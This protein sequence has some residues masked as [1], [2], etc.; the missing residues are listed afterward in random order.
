M[1]RHLLFFLLFINSLLLI[2]QVYYKAN[3]FSVED[4][5]AQSYVTDCVQDNHGF[6]WFSTWNGLCRYDGYTFH[7]FKSEPGLKGMLDNNRLLKIELNSTGNLWCIAYGQNLYLFDVNKCQY[8][9]VL[10]QI[11]EKKA[12]KKYIIAV[13]PLKKGVSWIILEDGCSYRINDKNLR[14]FQSFSSFSAINKGDSIYQVIQDNSGREWI[15][16][17]KGVSILGGH[18]YNNYPFSYMVEFN[19]Q[20]YL[21][22]KDGHFACCN[23]SLENL[24]FIKLPGKVSQINQMISL[25]HQRLAF[26]TDRG[27]IIYNLA[28]NTFKTYNM[29]SLGQ[30]SC[31]VV[32]MYPDSKKRLWVFTKGPGVSCIDLKHE[33]CEWFTTEKRSYTELLKEIG[34]YVEDLNGTI[35]IM[36]NGGA[37]SYFDEYSHSLKCYYPISTDFSVSLGPNLRNFHVDRQQNLW[38]SLYHGLFRLSFYKNQFS[39]FPSIKEKDMRSFL[40]DHLGRL[41][42]GDKGGNLNVSDA[43]GKLIGYISSQG[44]LSNVVSPFSS[45][46]I[47]CMREDSQHCVWIGTKGQGLFLLVP[48]N[49]NCNRYKVQHYHSGDSGSY[50]LNNDNIYSIFE[51]K[52]YHVW[53]GTF[54]GGLNLMKKTSNGKML[55]VNY[56]NDLK[57]YPFD[58]FKNVRCITGNKRGELLVGTTKGLLTFSSAFCQAE[59]IDFYENIHIP[60]DIRSL[61][62]NDVKQVII[63]KSGRSFVCTFGGGVNEV[64]SGNLLSNNIHFKIYQSKENPALNLIESAALDKEGNI[65]VVSETSISRFTPLAGKFDV[66]G[67]S[68]FERSY[69]FLET[70]PII[71]SQGRLI[72]GVEGGRLVFDPKRVHKSSFKPNIVFSGVKFQGENFIHTLNDLSNLRLTK[73]QRSLTIYFSAIDYMD[74]S[75]IR[76]AY[77]LE[78]IDNDWSYTDFSHSA[79]YINLPAGDYKFLIHST[80]SEGVWT[81]NFRTLSVHIVPTFWETPWCWFMYLL[82]F[83][84]FTGVI[85]YIL[86]YIYRLRHQVDMEQKIT[87]I[88]LEFFTDISHE[89]RTPL[90]LIS[91][92]INEVLSHET[93]SKQGRD[94]LELVQKNTSRMLQLINQI[95][96]FRKIQSNHVRLMVEE[97]NIIEYLHQ[98]MEHFRGIAEDKHIIFLFDNNIDEAKLWIDKDKFQKIVFNLISNAFKYTPDGKSILIKVIDAAETLTVAVLDE[99]IGIS[100]F[101]IKSIFERFITAFPGNSIQP[102][103][104]IGLSLVKKLV[105]LHHGQ[106]HVQS[107]LGKGSCFSVTF[108]KGCEHFLSDSLAELIVNDPPSLTVEDEHSE[109]QNTCDYERTTILVVEDNL[110]LCYFLTSILQSDYRI[111][112][113][114]NG[115]EG[116]QKAENELPDFIITDIMMP[117]MDGMEMIRRIKADSS[118]CH[119]PIVVL[120]AKSSLDDRIEGLEN[121]IDD[122]ITKPFSSSYLKSRVINLIKQ[123]QMLQQAFMSGCMFSQQR[124]SENHFELQ[125]PQI[126][127]MD[128]QFMQKLMSYLEENI[129]NTELAIDDIA[130]ELN[131]SRSIF[132]RKLKTIVGMAPVDFIRQIRIKRA[133]QLLKAGEDSLA[134]IAYQ[135]GFSDPRYFGKCF[136]R[137]MN[138]PPSEY[139]QKLRRMNEKNETL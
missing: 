8:I 127:S 19:H 44:N 109:C 60:G 63:T 116:L 2:A 7:S 13:Y 129:G 99:G 100:D 95:L 119:I 70:S 20:I 84:L 94:Y 139:K 39:F 30:L 69:N 77:K 92:P 80:N 59:A 23:H 90:T 121:G 134:Q 136:K 128:K 93:L 83:A 18:F 82:L 48:L 79:N 50:T 102:S 68:S 24:R 67:R 117:V 123:R 73:K 88:K 62:G 3:T 74:P 131:M 4:G 53:I 58:D 14:E 130:D 138:M 38:L 9:D 37:F 126:V 101:Q 54:G 57:N 35:W 115:Q 137:E 104:G 15:F 66:Y 32:K 21:A 25:D 27:T 132:Y 11:K 108:L 122:Y 86:F 78:G 12:H 85:V 22:S 106:I 91:S 97:V 118:I 5:L 29:L 1:K 72:V 36:P 46:G 65:W 64:V 56:S 17:N 89:L 107:S 51:D 114:E 45:S 55:F 75:N 42:V 61:Q 103:T 16:S 43:A 105:Q 41:W 113:A 34:L 125:T 135:V 33:R 133:V 96:D 111:I 81:N 120:S 76:Y 26:G 49:A 31:E 124:S 112:Q 28:D 52:K 71:D 87:D 47:Y 110:E 40:N 98:I 10:K 6:M